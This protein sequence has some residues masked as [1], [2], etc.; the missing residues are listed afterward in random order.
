MK[1]YYHRLF[2]E[3]G[4]SVDDV[5]KAYRKLVKKFHP[6]TN[7]GKTEYVKEF[8]LIQE[9]YEKLLYHFKNINFISIDQD[10]EEN[11]IKNTESK[12]G[13]VKR[14]S[15]YNVIEYF[16]IIGFIICGICAAINQESII[17]RILFIIVILF[18]VLFFIWNKFKKNKI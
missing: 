18:L 13:K 2:L 15:H 14:E 16:L 9:A 4:A 11:H 12:T 8:Q 17:I 3:D 10:N 6:D 5:K 7:E 1:E